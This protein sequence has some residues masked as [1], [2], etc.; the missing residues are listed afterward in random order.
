MGL[1]GGQHG[2]E[3]RQALLHGIKGVE[4][5]LLVLLHVLVV[6]KG[7]ALQH[8]EGAQEIA[9]DPA[10]LAP[11]QLR[12]VGVLLLRHDGGA[13]GVCV[14]ELH[15][16]ELPA[17]PEDDLL[18]E[19]GEVHHNGRQGRQ[20]LHA[21]VPVGD[22]VDAVA[23]GAV[24]AQ[25][26]GGHFPVRGVGGARQGAGPQ[27][28]FVHAPGGILKAG[29]IP[30][31]HHAVGQKL[32]GEEDGLG[33]LQVGI[34]GDDG[35]RILLRLVGN[36]GKELTELA[37]HLPALLPE[38]EAEVQGHL[39]VAAPGSVELFP[40][41]PQPL[42]ED[43]LHE[44]VDVL[45]GGV[46]G[47]LAALDVLQNVREAPCQL[48][49][50]LRGQDAALL[51]HG[52]VGQGT[53]DVLTVHAAVNLNGGIEGVRRLI[54]LSRRPSGPHFRHNRFS[55]PKKFS[56]PCVPRPAA[57]YPR[58]PFRRRARRKNP[59]HEA[60]CRSLSSAEARRPNEALLA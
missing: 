22:G 7:Q 6:G 52:R 48:R 46:N 50:L 29:D 47:E 26:G 32:L 16:V 59:S 60:K 12:H 43:L 57:R 15:K 1:H 17:G 51:Q 38:P 19:A 54:Q 28:G 18:A 37:P 5:G 14:R 3:Y 33:P 4:D 9:V 10:G 35:V 25:G 41:V 20:Q 45:G 30:G 13:G 55:V 11:D 24:K 34:A 42:G 27:R 49:R 58:D 8:G 36:D 31:E 56:R 40:H 2:G 53:D 21:E 39:V 44:H 23:A